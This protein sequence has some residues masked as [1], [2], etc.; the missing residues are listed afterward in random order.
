MKLFS[1]Y[2]IIEFHL[3]NHWTFVYQKLHISHKAFLF[4]SCFEFSLNWSFLESIFRSTEKCLCQK[5][6][7]SF[8]CCAITASRYGLY[9][10]TFECSFI[11]LQ[12]LHFVELRSTFGLQRICVCDKSLDW[13]WYNRLLMKCKCNIWKLFRMNDVERDECV[14]QSNSCLFVVVF[15]IA[16]QWL[17]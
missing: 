8:P 4:Q 7:S 12:I 11:A 16:V 5:I 10:S 6:M 3:C 9:N 14:V 2:H 15:F 1:K 13:M 17:Q